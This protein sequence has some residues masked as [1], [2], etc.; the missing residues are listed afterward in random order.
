MNTSVE[1]NTAAPESLIE[2]R[3]AAQMNTFLLNTSFE[4]ENAEYDNN[5]LYGHYTRRE[6]ELA[7]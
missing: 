1:L 6:S 7:E 4:N 3:S 2:R 5:E